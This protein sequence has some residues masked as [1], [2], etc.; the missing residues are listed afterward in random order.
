MRGKLVLRQI[1]FNAKALF[2]VLVEDEDR[3][4]PDNVK[5]V[6]AGWVLLYVDGRREKVFFNEVCQFLIGV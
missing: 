3:R 6:E 1:A 5:A 4:S 2:A